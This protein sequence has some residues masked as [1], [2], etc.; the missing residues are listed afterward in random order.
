MTKTSNRF[1]AFST[2][3]L[4]SLVIFSVFI[5]TLLYLW[6]PE[7]FFTASG[8][9]QGLKIV[10]LI[11]LI[12]GPVLTF[13]IFNKNKA[14]KELRNDIIIIVVLQMSALMWGVYTVHAQ[15][16]VAVVYWD[17]MFYTVS[18]ADIINQGLSVDILDTYGNNL[19]VYL[20]TPYPET[21]EERQPIVERMKNNKIPPFQQ[22]E[23]YTSMEGNHSKIFQHSLD[24]DEV[25]SSNQ[26]MHEELKEV[27][28]Q[29]GTQL[30]DNHY[31]RLNSKFRNIVLIFDQSNSI[32]GTISAPF[33][34]R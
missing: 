5:L 11:D 10:A 6:Y 23:L 8:G 19:P 14:Y 3:F 30:H 9:W 4:L 18:A 1:I 17:S 7:P 13:I 34:N 33:K 15:R 24:I 31:M 20:Y 16:P 2:H 26:E 25:I 12:L 21:P 29:T 22:T 32:I 27:L 28:R